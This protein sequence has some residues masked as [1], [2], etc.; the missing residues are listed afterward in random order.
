MVTLHHLVHGLSLHEIVIHLV[1]GFQLHEAAL[2]VVGVDHGA[3]RV[4][5][6]AVARRGVEHGHHLLQV[7][8]AEIEP[9]AP[10]VEVVLH[11]TAQAV[12]SL[13]WLPTEVGT[14]FPRAA[15]GVAAHHVH[16]L[17]LAVGSLH[18]ALG[19]GIIGHFLLVD[20]LALMGSRPVLG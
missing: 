15:H 7:V 12:K 1:S 11:V 13:A 6:Q 18:D 2:L 14:V 10:Q 4:E 9:L 5:K 17:L 3:P 16:H 8:L 19:A 20:G